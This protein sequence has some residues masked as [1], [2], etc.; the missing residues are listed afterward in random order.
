MNISGPR[1][2]RN[3]CRIPNYSLLAVISPLNQ[4]RVHKKFSEIWI[5]QYRKKP[6]FKWSLKKNV[7]ISFWLMLLVF[8]KSIAV[9]EGY[10][11]YPAAFLIRFLL[12]SVVWYWDGKTEVLGEKS[13]PASI[14]SPHI[15]HGLTRDG[16]PVSALRGRRLNAEAT[17]SIPFMSIW[18]LWWSEWRW[19]R[20]PSIALFSF[21][22][23]CA[24]NAVYLFSSWIATA[25][26]TTRRRL[27]TVRYKMLFCLYLVTFDRKVFPCCFP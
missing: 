14:W 21:C 25:I 27:E 2:A 19:K 4:K 16:T 10:P 6:K 8:R 26:M 1:I 13:V 20:F 22:Q 5:Q 15:W 23:N 18:Y 9:F 17:V 7:P 24:I 11:V 3:F 12:T